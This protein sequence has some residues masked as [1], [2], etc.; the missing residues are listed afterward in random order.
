MASNKPGITRIGLLTS[1]IIHFVANRT[2]DSILRVND[3]EQ[4]QFLQDN[5]N[6]MM[7]GLF[8]EEV[9]F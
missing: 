9:Y 7:V 5:G 6:V 1:D 8:D 4:I 2:E 3:I